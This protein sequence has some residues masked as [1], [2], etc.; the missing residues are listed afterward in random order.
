MVDAAPPVCGTA[1]APSAVELPEMAS[2]LPLLRLTMW[3]VPG[4]GP[5]LL[6]PRVKYSAASLNV[7]VPPLLV[8][9]TRYTRE[10]L[11]GAVN[12]TG[13]VT[14]EPSGIV[15]VLLPDAMTVPPTWLRYAVQVKPTEVLLKSSLNTV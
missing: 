4:V 8:L 1:L 5:P 10:P 7:A 14:R 6:P 3:Y 13:W 15:R 11:L 9:S 2:G 12:V